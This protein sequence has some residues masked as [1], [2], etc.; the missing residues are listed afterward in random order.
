MVAQKKAIV[1][2][3]EVKFRRNDAQGD[4]FEYITQQKRHK[5]AFAAEIWK[6]HYNWNGDYGL[7][8]AAV[9]GLD[10]ENIELVEV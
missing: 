5:M 9:S 1:Y 7:M 2:F 8:A 4:G 3:V 6:Q 10:C